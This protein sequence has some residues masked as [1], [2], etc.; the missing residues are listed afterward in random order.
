MWK[1][2][3]LVVVG[4]GNMG[5]ALALGVLRS[6]LLPASSILAIDPSEACRGTMVHAG[7]RSFA[8]LSQLPAHSGSRVILLAI[9]PQKLSEFA[10][11][12]AA[13]SGAGSCTLTLSILA[14]VSR[15][16]VMQALGGDIPCIRAMPNLPAL[17]G[18]GATAV[19]DDG[20]REEHA[21]FAREVFRSV[22]PCVQ[23]LDESLLDAFTAVAGSGPAYVFLLAEAMLAGAKQTGMP[24]ELAREAI[25][26]TCLGAAAMLREPGAHAATLRD[27]VTSPGGTTQAALQV[28]MKHNVPGALQEAVIAARDRA[29]ELGLSNR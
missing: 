29:R 11:E 18:Q 8:A 15:S 5:G 7:I 17:L 22:G 23:Q 13:W 10:Q 25:A 3:Q 26:Q 16:R 28:L 9:K 20:A 21:A 24:E 4:A 6:G 19:C 1:C 14:G 27:R 12:F 2:D